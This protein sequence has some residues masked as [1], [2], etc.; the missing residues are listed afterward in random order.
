MPISRVHRF[1]PDF[2]PLQFALNGRKGRRICC[3]LGA[4][5]KVLEVLDMD[6]EEPEEEEATV[7]DNEDGVIQ[8][9]LPDL[10]AGSETGLEEYEAHH[11]TNGYGSDA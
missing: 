6:I 11:S 5:G 4:Q 7:A 8:M 3:V 9:E 1:G 2:E 10:L